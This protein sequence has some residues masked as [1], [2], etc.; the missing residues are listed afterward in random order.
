MSKELILSD[1]YLTRENLN[2]IQED[3]KEVGNKILPALKFLES[4][5]ADW[6]DGLAESGSVKHQDHIELE[7]AVKQLREL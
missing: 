7:E 2:S 5:L 6:N 1:L 3:L 4:L